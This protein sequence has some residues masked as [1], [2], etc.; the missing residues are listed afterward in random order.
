MVQVRV[1][2]R[3]MHYPLILVNQLTRDFHMIHPLR[4]GSVPGFAPNGVFQGRLRLT[5]TAGTTQ[6]EGRR[7]SRW[8][9]GEPRPPPRFMTFLFSIHRSLSMI[10][11]RARFAREATYKA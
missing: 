8:V 7:W 11:R 6:P 2:I 1:A 4:V 9:S 10:A 5:V 3:A